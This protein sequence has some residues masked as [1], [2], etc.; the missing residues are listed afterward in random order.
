MQ[1]REWTDAEL[2]DLLQEQLPHEL[3]MQQIDA[4]RRQMRRSPQVREALLAEL[5]LEHGVATHLA[6]RLDEPDDFVQRIEAMARS[7]SRSRW[8][9]FG[10]MIL[11]TTSLLG[12][13]AGLLFH[14]GQTPTKPPALADATDDDDKDTPTDVPTTPTPTPGVGEA[15]TPPTAATVQPGTASPDAASDTATGQTIPDEPTPV[16]VVDPANPPEPDP[17]WKL[18]DDPTARGDM[19]WLASVD[20]VLRPIGNARWDYKEDNQ[21]IDLKGQYAM[22]PPTADGRAVRLRFNGVQHFNVTFWRGDRAARV[23]MTSARNLLGS[24]IERQP[25]KHDARKMFPEG[26]DAVFLRQSIKQR[27]DETIDFNWA[28]DSPMKDVPPDDFAVRWSGQLLA[29]EQGMYRFHLTSDDGTTLY[30]DGKRVIDN[31]YNQSATERHADIALDKGPHDIVVEYFEASG[32]SVVKLEWASD[33]IERQVIPPTALRTSDQRDAKPG[34]LGRYCYGDRLN[35]EAPQR[36]YAVCDDNWKWRNLREGA[37]DFR[38]EEGQ[39]IVARGEALLLTVPMTGPP[40]RA[41]LDFEGQLHLAEHLRVEP[42]ATPVVT[43]PRDQK[44]DKVAWSADTS[45]SKEGVAYQVTDDHVTLEQ[46]EKDK[47]G[48]LNATHPLRGGS[49]VTIRVDEATVG[50]GVYFRST[51]N[52]AAVVMHLAERDGR[53]LFC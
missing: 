46:H 33:S 13:T 3:S 21:R 45:M 43:A 26:T 18:F 1:N 5:R 40:Q 38:Y 9:G 19:R 16:T 30:I 51:V 47:H 23:Q 44:Q 49:Q 11:L 17:A 20:D 2:I 50:A 25:A 35:G 53:L 34:L 41:V 6:P 27:I 42:L 8:I 15:D 37:I 7:R 10:L 22:T 14:F 48:R 36:I 39:L 12:G 32:D 29:P 4:L 31:W 28:S 52:D 24:V